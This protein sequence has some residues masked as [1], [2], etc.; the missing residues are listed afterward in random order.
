MVDPENRVVVS[1]SDGLGRTKKTI[2]CRQHTGNI[3]NESQGL[4]TRYEYNT[5]GNVTKVTDSAGV[6]VTTNTYDT[7]GRKKATDDAD[8][9]H[10]EYNYDKN[11]NLVWQKDPQGN[12]TTFDYDEL[13]RLEKKYFNGTETLSYTYDQGDYGIGRKHSFSD[14]Y[15]TTTYTYDQRGR[16]LSES[17]SFA[18]KDLA[19]L[20][21][22]DSYVTGYSYDNLD[23]MIAITYPGTPEFGAETVNY[24]YDG[25]YLESVTGD[26]TYVSNI[27]YNTFGQITTRELGN[28]ITETF[29]YDS[30]NQRLSTLDVGSNI[31]GLS[32]NY[33]T[34]G[35]I[36]RITDNIHSS[37]PDLSMS[38]AFTY[39]NFYRL[40]SASG[41]YDASFVYDDLDRMTDKTEGSSSQ[42][43]GFSEARPYHGI[44]YIGDAVNPIQYDAGGN[45]LSYKIGD[46]GARDITWNYGIGKPARIEITPPDTTPPTSTLT[47]TADS[48]DCM[49]SDQT[50]NDGIIE[51]EVGAEDDIALDRVEFERGEWTAECVGGDIDMCHYMSTGA[52]WDN[53]V[54]HLT[55]EGC[56][57]DCSDI[58]DESLCG[59]VP[60]CSWGSWNWQN[61]SGY[62]ETA[63]TNPYSNIVS[64]TGQ[65]G[66]TYQFR[67]RAKDTA[68]NWSDWVE[69]GKVTVEILVC[70]DGN[71]SAGEECDPPGSSCPGEEVCLANCSCGTDV[72]LVVSDITRDAYYYKVRYCNEGTQTS[73]DQLLVKIKNK[74][75]GASFESNYLYPYGIPDPGQCITTS[76][77]TCGLIGSS[78]DD[79]ITVEATVDSRNTVLETNEDN[80]TYEKSF[81]IPTHRICQNEACVTVEGAGTDECQ[82]DTDCV[83][84]PECQTNADCNDDNPCTTDACT[85][86]VCEHTNIA[87][88]TSCA[89]SGRPFA[90]G[91]Y[92][93]AGEC[94][95]ARPPIC[96]RV[97]NPNPV[98]RGAPAILDSSGSSDPNPG[99]SI[100]KYE[101]DW[102]GNGTYD[103]T[104][105]AVSA[106][107]GVFDGKTEH[108]FNRDTRVIFRVT[109]NYGKQATCLVNVRTF[110]YVPLFTIEPG[111]NFNLQLPQG[112]NMR[113]SE[114]IQLAKKSYNACDIANYIST[115]KDGWLVTYLLGWGGEDFEIKGGETKFIMKNN[116]DAPCVVK[117]KEFG[118]VQ[119]AVKGTSVISTEFFYNGEGS[120]IAK[121]Q[122]DNNY[123]LYINA[124]L[125][126]SVVDGLATWRKNY[127][128]GGK[129][130]AVRLINTCTP[131]CEGKNCG[132]DGC[133]GSCPP[134]CGS[135]EHCSSG[136]CTCYLGYTNCSG[137]CVNLQTDPNNC[138]SCANVCVA[139]DVACKFGV[140]GPLTPPCFTAKT[141]VALANGQSVHIENLEIGDKVLGFDR[142][143]DVKEAKVVKLI[144]SQRES[145]FIIS[146]K[147]GQRVETTAEHPFLTWSRQ[148]KKVEDLKAGDTVFV[149]RGQKLVLSKITEKAEVNE[150]V[151]V[152]NL[153]VA[154]PNTFFAEGFAVHNKNPIPPP[155]D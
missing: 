61:V 140:C 98:E 103:Y 15:Q 138:G 59:S 139:P 71:V 134:G 101:F 76:G 73:A 84:P 85:D 122:D 69:S 28:N 78:C 54:C 94:I 44:K 77:F 144:K 145:Y 37:D 130:V 149:L 51:L 10:W 22:S 92:C 83:A 20:F 13:N 5:L 25:I 31:L 58:S 132:D 112:R 108:T 124:Y 148:F 56:V 111:V 154:S 52:C 152:Y 118:N 49:T 9:G 26:D 68:G 82:S 42:I 40:T 97:V 72:D 50:D 120:R 88:G 74:D 107:D 153:Q 142:G 105:T 128:A 1:V 104:E 66:E 43:F 79:E 86:G 39:D 21:G 115:E 150:S 117:I 23:R 96:K 121:K 32:Y 113:A 34:V 91:Y 6:D 17:K 89:P 57:G 147:D 102:D 14:D 16:L 62:P 133:G 70:G 19:S 95:E 146:T 24:T 100:T 129:L 131:D 29:S 7:L 135:H 125:E 60:D 136:N 143:L 65:D 114:V 55:A 53:P 67:T 63:P 11:G 93:Q 2:N 90:T 123:V 80:N 38:Q 46:I 155:I 137:N 106:S 64:F 81:L 4:V 47:C 75:T 110:V 48:G 3:C 87:D 35:N 30:L 141:A 151:T 8:L 116:G 45:I 109:S 18:G 127:L 33:S 126:K 99:G 36:T 41:A 27:D 12:E 119:G